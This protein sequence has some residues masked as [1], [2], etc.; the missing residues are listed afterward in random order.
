MS[1]DYCKDMENDIREY[2]KNNINLADFEDKKELYEYL[3]DELWVEDSVTGNGSG[4][5]TF[6]R[7]TAKEYVFDNTDLC[8][9]ALEDFC[10]DSGTVA[11]KFLSEDFEYF[12]VTIRCYLLGGVISMVLDKME[13]EQELW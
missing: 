5:Y 12:D 10:I 11:D 9:E 6:C 8:V 1:Y 7:Q 2:I 13:S 3:N 4:S